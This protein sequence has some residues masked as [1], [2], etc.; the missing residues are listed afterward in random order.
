MAKVKQAIPF[1]IYRDEFIAA[2]ALRTAMGLGEFVETSPQGLRVAPIHIRIPLVPIVKQPSDQNDGEGD[3]WKLQSA[4]AKKSALLDL[5]LLDDAVRSYHARLLELNHGDLFAERDALQAELATPTSPAFQ[6]PVNGYLSYITYNL[7][8]REKF[9]Q[10]PFI[11]I[12]SRDSFDQNLYAT[13]YALINYLSLQSG[14]AMDVISLVG[15]VEK[16]LKTPTLENVLAAITQQINDLRALTP[17]SRKARNEK[18]RESIRDLASDSDM[19]R[20]GKVIYANGSVA[21]NLGN[22]DHDP[23]EMVNFVLFQPEFYNPKKFAELQKFLGEPVTYGSAA[24]APFII[25]PEMIKHKSD[26]AQLAAMAFY[27]KTAKTISEMSFH[28]L[29]A[30]TRQ[31]LNKTNRASQTGQTVDMGEDFLTLLFLADE[32]QN[33]L[34][35]KSNPLLFD[36]ITPFLGMDM[37]SLR[38]QIT[39]KRPYLNLDAKIL[40]AIADPDQPMMRIW[41]KNIGIKPTMSEKL[42]GIMDHVSYWVGLAFPRK[43]IFRQNVATAAAALCLFFLPVVAASVRAVNKTSEF[44]RSIPAQTVG[45]T[46]D[47]YRT[48]QFDPEYGGFR[49]T[50]PPSVYGEEKTIKDFSNMPQTMTANDLAAWQKSIDARKNEILD[51]C[52]NVYWNKPFAGAIIGAIAV[53]VAMAMFRRRTQNR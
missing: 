24:R 22:L 19:I 50:T 14:T 46:S 29:M 33:R 3:E 23:D 51:E 17:D 10:P 28:Q 26:A 21:V 43:G 13:F 27:R 25:A 8:A 11:D 38:G 53:P 9:R 35:S 47:P 36:D 45:V 32:M 40:N 5:G 37:E 6:N 44:M 12:K 18:I 4:A 15:E 1:N 16:N 52:Q 42:S 20:Q 2:P 39:A 49:D 41:G 31:L 7:A 34:D 48:Y 30:T